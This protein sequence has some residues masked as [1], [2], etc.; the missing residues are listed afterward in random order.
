[1]SLLS[2]TADPMHRERGCFVSNGFTDA[3]RGSY[4]ERDAHVHGRLGN[5]EQVNAGVP[6]PVLDRL[7]KR[8]PRWFMD[9][10]ASVGTWQ[11]GVKVPGGA[12]SFSVKVSFSSK[13]AVGCY[14]ASYDEM[15]LRNSQAVSDAL[16][17]LYCKKGNDW[18]LKREW[19]IGAVE[20]RSGFIAMSNAK[21]VAVTLAGTGTMSARRRAD[22][23]R[24]RRRA[25]REVAL[26]RDGRAEG[27]HTLC[28]ACR[29]EGWAVGEGDLGPAGMSPR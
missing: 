8:D 10:S 2:K 12:V 6:D 16:A 28:A 3:E 22:R 5:L 24:G 17:K 25:G 7:A 18:T 14:L 21:E 1:M 27:D 4:G 29:G 13:H 19:A 15:Q 9:R 11:S 23:L 26:R 20:L